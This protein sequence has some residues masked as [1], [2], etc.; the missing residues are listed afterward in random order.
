MALFRVLCWALIFILKLRIPP[1]S[2]L[3][4]VNLCCICLDLL[5][6]HKFVKIL[7]GSNHLLYCTSLLLSSL[8]TACFVNRG[9]LAQT[10]ER[11]L[12]MREVAG[13]MPAS[14]TSFLLFL[15]L[16][17]GYTIF[18]YL[19]RSPSQIPVYFTLRW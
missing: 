9:G 13:S 15:F 11:A 16:F 3:A 8:F 7:P 10:V 1:G 19:T 14:S 18:F 5:K 4:M 2:S 6:L 17:L 12:C